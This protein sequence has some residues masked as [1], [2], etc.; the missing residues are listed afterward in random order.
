ML[1]NPF[2]KKAD[3]RYLFEEAGGA[4]YDNYIFPYK[5]YAE[6]DQEISYWRWIGVAEQLYA[7]GFLMSRLKQERFYLSRSTRI[8]L[9]LFELSSEN[10]RILKKCDDIE[11]NMVE[12][13]QFEYRPE[14]GKMAIDF[15]KTRFGDKKISAQGWKRIFT[16]LAFNDILIFT[17][18]S[19]QRI[20]GYCPSV[21]AGNLLH[22]AYPFYDLSYLDHNI[23][24]GMILKTL[25]HLKSHSNYHKY[26]YLGTCYTESALYKTQFKGFEWFDGNSWSNDTESLKKLVRSK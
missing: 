15:Y 17:D 2:T 24:I 16:Q 25:L 12:A 18:R 9:S 22:Y 11:I 5:V 7:K 3:I 14:I 23:G 21:D 26:L 8:D 10:R 13:H 6:V 19:N 20:V 4:D 1:K